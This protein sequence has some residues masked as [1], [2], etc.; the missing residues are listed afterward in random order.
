MLDAAA[1]VGEAFPF[2]VGET[3]RGAV[4]EHHLLP[5]VFDDGGGESGFVGEVVV[6]RADRHAAVARHAA[7]AQ[8]GEAALARVAICFVH[9]FRAGCCAHARHGSSVLPAAGW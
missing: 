1:E 9:D 8:R 6:Q 2:V 5:E 3:R 7:H 4:G